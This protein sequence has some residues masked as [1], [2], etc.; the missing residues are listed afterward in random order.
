METMKRVS[1]SLL[2]LRTNPFMAFLRVLVTPP[3]DTGASMRHIPHWYISRLQECAIYRAI[4]QTP[5]SL[6]S[7]N[8]LRLGEGRIRGLVCGFLA[9]CLFASYV[10]AE[11]PT[12]AIEEI[13]GIIR[14]EILSMSEWNDADVRVEIKGEVKHAQGES[15]RLAPEGLTISRRNTLAP[16][17]V[18]NNGKTMR[19]LWVPATVHV[20]VPAIVASRKIASGVIITT[21][22]I[23]EGR[24]ETTDIGSALIR[25]PK[26]ITGKIS[27]RSFAPGDLL[28]A[29]AFSEPPLVRR[30]DMV[31][32]RLERNGIVLTSAAR[33]AEN[34][35]LGEIV[36]VKSVDFSSVIKARVIGQSEVSVQ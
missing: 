14:N 21:D 28:P 36:R 4:F 29:D 18:I 15:F 9:F 8:F 13:S 23:C 7:F 20:S 35:R 10:V 2:I 6:R 5:R 17:E 1:N 22:D 16:I 25:D 11:T 34:G 26:E 19:S 32:L 30:G 31:S 27:R 24:I 33:A 12:S 3:G